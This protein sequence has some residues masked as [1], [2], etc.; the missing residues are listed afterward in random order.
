MTAPSLIG[1]FPAGGVP[2][3]TTVR[4]HTIAHTRAFDRQISSATGDPWLA[5]V[6]PNAGPGQPVVITAGGS[7]TIPLTL[8]P[9]G[10]PGNVIH[11]TL[12]VDTYNTRLDTGGEVA[13]LPCPT[14]TPSTVLATRRPP[15]LALAGPRTSAARR[16]IGG[17]SGGS[18]C[19]GIKAR[20]R[21]WRRASS[22]LLRRGGRRGKQ[23]AVASAGRLPAA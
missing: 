2:A 15:P 23:N 12:Y 13:A 8:T 19:R 20:P 9:T 10:H 22:A 14:R 7:A 16:P 6:D 1:P 18:S 21:G 11:G 3:V 17:C 4:L 5:T